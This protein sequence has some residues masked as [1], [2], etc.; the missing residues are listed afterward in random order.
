MKGF[1]TSTRRGRQRYTGYYVDYGMSSRSPQVAKFKPG[2]GEL[3]TE[4]HRGS[5]EATARKAGEGKRGP[6]R[7]LGPMD[8]V[9]QVRFTGDW[10]HGQLKI[11]IEMRVSPRCFGIG[12]ARWSVTL[13]ISFLYSIFPRGSANAGTVSAST[14]HPC[15]SFLLCGCWEPMRAAIGAQAYLPRPV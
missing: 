1:A 8:A 15:A 6:A 11:E 10:S 14:G 13:S 3:R 9:L 7:R 5:R 4:I 12:L 2:N